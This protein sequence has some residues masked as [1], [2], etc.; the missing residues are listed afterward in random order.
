MRRCL[1]HIVH[2]F[3]ECRLRVVIERIPQHVIFSS[4]REGFEHYHVFSSSELLADKENVLAN[5]V[6]NAPILKRMI[7]DPSQY[8]GQPVFVVDTN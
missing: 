2:I 3:Y 7:K 8:Y 1:Q 6:T 5:T 4:T